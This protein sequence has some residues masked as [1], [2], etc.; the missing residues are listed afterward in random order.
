MKFGKILKDFSEARAVVVEKEND[1]GTRGYKRQRS[2]DNEG[3]MEQSG[4]RDF[5]RYKEMKK[6]LK[7]AAA[8]KES[9]KEAMRTHEKEFIRM[10]YDD[11]ERI[12]SYFIEEEENAVIKLQMV[13]EMYVGA[14]VIPDES[15]TTHG[16]GTTNNTSLMDEAKCIQRYND[17]MHV[18]RSRLID[19]HGELVLLLHWSIVNYA[20]ILKIL[21]KHDKLLGGHAQKNLVGSILQQPFTSTE[22]ITNLVN[23][24]ERY[25]RM[26]AGHDKAQQ[27]SSNPPD[28]LGHGDSLSTLIKE[29]NEYITDKSREGNIVMLERTAAA[30]GMLQ[31]LQST[32]ASPST[33]VSVDGDAKSFW[34]V[35]N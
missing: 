19:L 18:I 16:D 35:E 15:A 26:L 2:D 8:C 24:A 28:T 33:L 27:E 12:N 32:A 13:Q 1:A 11:V 7:R 4:S 30:L 20:G 9:D 10:L 21:K 3:D 25:V 6:L 34:N 14:A 29:A 17:A 5:V 31:Q 23:T 22:S